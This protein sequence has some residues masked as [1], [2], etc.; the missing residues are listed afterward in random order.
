[1]IYGS[2]EFRILILDV[3]TRDK[4]HALYEK[5]VECANKMRVHIYGD[6]PT[7]LLARVRP[8][9]PDEIRQYREKNYEPTTKA[10]ASKALS[11][12]GKIFNPWLFQIKWHNQ[13]NN[14]KKLEDYALQ[15]YPKHNSVLKFLSEAGMKRMVAD[16]NGIFAIRPQDVPDPL[17]IDSDLKQIYPEIKIFGSPNIWYYDR[18][19]FLI[20]IKSEE[21][22]EGVL[23][24]FEYYDKLQVVEFTARAINQKQVVI[25]E[26]LRYLH[27]FKEIPCWFLTGETETQDNGEEYYIS[28]FEP[29]L[30]FW[31]K[32]ITH[33]SDLD[34]AFIMHLHPQ[35]VVVAEDC[36]F[37]HDDQ[38]C[39]H[40][41]IALG[42]GTYE[43]CP[44][45]KGSGKRIPIGPYGVHM[46]AKEK[47]DAGQQMNVPVQ[48]VTVPTDPTK[49]LKERVDE[50]H[51]KGL[52][53]LNMDVVDK[54]GENQ[55]GIAKVIDRGEL[56]DFL[57][58]ISDVVFDTHLQNI[59]YYFNKYMFGVV[60]SNPNRNPDANLP[61]INK[62]TTFDLSSTSEMTKDYESA[63]KAGVSPEYLRQKSI[64]ITSK[65]YASTPDVKKRLIN[66]LE[67]DPLPELTPADMEIK[68][69]VGTI[70]KRDAVIHDNIG[71]FVNRAILDHKDFFALQKDEKLE[72][73]GA[74]ADEFISENRVKLTVDETEEA[75]RG[76][77]EEG[78]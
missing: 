21:V 67:L 1:M 39:Q 27:N 10:T 58:K 51:K 31:N 5:T 61:D 63:K 14:G 9:E 52:E 12:L 65:E 74:Y 24:Y 50:Q 15:N 62:P 68:L 26:T 36:D 8:R 66:M 57:Y 20:H 38:R 13:T 33:E 4:R 46:V 73:L 25:T 11:I 72:I 23:H 3:L 69:S 76:N 32:A 42:D 40:G 70:S 54:V 47:L 29:A 60:D 45:C 59:F 53:A 48:Y 64:S 16:P 2:E 55:S 56:Y 30:P 77:R 37:V 71:T 49:M 34:A 19:H 41:K 28:F 18:D 17:E 44:S 43:T 78:A 22:K 35:K 7:E 75:G 6:T